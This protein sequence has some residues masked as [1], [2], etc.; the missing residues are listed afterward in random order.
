M[1]VKPGKAFSHHD[2]SISLESLSEVSIIG[3]SA[4]LKQSPSKFTSKVPASIE[5][6]HIF[7]EPFSPTDFTS[8]A[9]HC[10]L[11]Y[12]SLAIALALS[13]FPIS[14]RLQDIGLR[15]ICASQYAIF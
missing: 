8:L 4:F 3:F 15:S 2:S 7:H 6:L 14:P 11:V 12:A 1:Q 10:W 9:T 5:E 13:Y